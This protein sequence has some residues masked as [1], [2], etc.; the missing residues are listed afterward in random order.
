MKLARKVPNNNMYLLAEKR[1]A[2]LGPTAR[3]SV[4]RFISLR[5][6]RKRRQV[7]ANE[8]LMV[9]ALKVE[10]NGRSFSNKNVLKCVC[11]CVP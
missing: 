6:S 5:M 1:L 9:E 4:E 3:N 11:M 8:E 10:S 2:E 7:S